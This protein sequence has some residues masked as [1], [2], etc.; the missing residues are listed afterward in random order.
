MARAYTKAFDIINLRYTDFLFYFYRSKKHCCGNVTK[1][2]SKTH[3]SLIRIIFF[4]VN[5]LA[6][7]L[8]PILFSALPSYLVLHCR[9][10][11]HGTSP[12]LLGI[13]GHSNWK[14]NI[15]IGFGSFAVSKNFCYVFHAI[16]GS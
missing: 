14:Q 10:S 15:P 9:N 7:Y 4:F 8:F 6:L 13:L 16:K 3:F 5:F 1:N 12:S 2:A 11:Y